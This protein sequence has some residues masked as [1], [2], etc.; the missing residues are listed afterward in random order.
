MSK[1]TVFFERTLVILEP[2][3]AESSF[4]FGLV[5]IL[6]LEIR[7]SSHDFSRWIVKVSGSSLVIE[8][9]GFVPWFPEGSPILLIG[10]MR[11]AIFI[12]GHC[13]LAC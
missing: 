1:L 4:I 2:V 5:Y 12:T 13:L 10:L 9:F 7:K 6:L 11:A 3:L 8:T